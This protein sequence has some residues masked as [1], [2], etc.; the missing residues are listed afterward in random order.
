MKKEDSTAVTQPLSKQN[1]RDGTIEREIHGAMHAARVSIYIEIVH[2]LNKKHQD[3]EIVEVLRALSERFNC[4]ELQLITLAKLSGLFHDIARQGEGIDNW[5]KESGQELFDYLTKALG[6]DNIL[7][8]VYQYVVMYKDKPEE[9]K[10]ALLS[11]GVEDALI[12]A[13]DYLRQLLS[14]ADC[15]D[16]IRCVG[17]FNIDK[18]E[19]YQIAKRKNN[20][21]L[22]QK[23]IEL[24]GNVHSLIHAQGDLIWESKINIGTSNKVLIPTH[25]TGS[26][27]SLKIKVGYEHASN[28]HQVILNSILKNPYF[29]GILKAQVRPLQAVEFIE[30]QFN[31]FLHGTNSSILALLP[32]TNFEFLSPLDMMHRYRMAPMAGEIFQ[33]GLDYLADG[34]MGFGRLDNGKKKAHYSLESI[35][36][37]YADPGYGKPT[38]ETLDK[39]LHMCIKFDFF[40]INQFLVSLCRARQWGIDISGLPSKEMLEEMT[41]TIQFY[42]L[43]LCIIDH[44]TPNLEGFK[45]HQVLNNLLCGA[46]GFGGYDG[47]IQEQFTEEYFKKIIKSKKLDL[48][49]I[50]QNPTKENLEILMQIFEINVG[51][52]KKDNADRGHEQI[53]LR[54]FCSSPKPN[55]FVAP[56]YHHDVEFYFK[57]LINIRYSHCGGTIAHRLNDLFYIMDYQQ[58]QGFVGIPIGEKSFASK[59]LPKTLYG[60]LE[61]QELTSLVVEPKGFHGDFKALADVPINQFKAFNPENLEKLQVLRPKLVQYLEKLEAR[62]ALLKSIFEDNMKFEWSVVEK[63]CFEKPFPIVLMTSDEE[64][65]QMF[66]IHG[67]EYRLKKNCQMFLGKQISLMATNNAENQKKLQE[68]LQKHSLD[69]PVVHFSDLELGQNPAPVIHHYLKLCLPFSEVPQ[70]ISH[71]PRQEPT[72]IVM[73]YLFQRHNVQKEGNANLG[74][75]QAAPLPK[76]VA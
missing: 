44:L 50:W 2:A 36:Q 6:L 22:V 11:L 61:A 28:V 4:D 5:E 74:S 15:L 70:I 45:Q 19:M 18:L 39:A 34:A 69:I 20:D 29:A 57:C 1:L 40:N 23:V 75:Q 16:I 38:F 52:D 37:N 24:V 27:F 14:N 33:G 41:L 65:I 64:S 59:N 66:D 31:P 62:F 73:G 42:Y 21:A 67:R 71:L 54:L 63:D 35:V 7:A 53:K 48:K 51:V 12:G 76:H 9:F 60:D 26:H 8:S 32:R 13:C 68:Y 55:K 30:A 47:K 3:K 49:A 56:R 46:K 17:Q 25:L 72:E 58:V 43:V 10:A